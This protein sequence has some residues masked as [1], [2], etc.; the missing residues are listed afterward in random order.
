MNTSE[1]N[2]MLRKKYEEQWDNVNLLRN[3]YKELSSPLLVFLEEGYISQK[4]RLLIVGQQTNGWN[5]GSI[6]NLQNCYRDF[7]MGQR[8]IRTPFW[9]FVH[10]LEKEFKIER[11][12]IVWTNINRCD[13]ACGKP[14]SDV[15]NDL[16]ILNPLLVTEI[17]AVRPHICIFLTGPN[18]DKR[19]KEI[20]KGVIFNEV[21]GFEKNQFA[22]LSHAIM[23]NETY[24]TYHPGYLRLSGKEDVV[25]NAFKSI[26]K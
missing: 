25:L 7:K 6:V 22:K 1:I 18:Y 14:P 4:I 8:Y 19:I 20:F 17:Q 5:E 9:N 23:P 13:Y 21:K 24:R 15:W 26:I 2:C 11:G 12:C 10:K 16:A 3:K